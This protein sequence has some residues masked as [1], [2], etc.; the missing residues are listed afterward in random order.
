MQENKQLKSDLGDYQ[1]L[2]SSLQN[3]LD[4]AYKECRESKDKLLTIRTLV[5]D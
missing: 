3:N 4:A 5:N 1:S 2:Q